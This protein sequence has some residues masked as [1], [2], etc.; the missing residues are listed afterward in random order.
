ML[1]VQVGAILLRALYFYCSITVVPISPPLLSSTLPTS[2]LP[3]SIKG[4]T[5]DFFGGKRTMK[6]A[7]PDW[8][9]PKVIYLKK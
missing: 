2:L 7:R 4:L 8:T 5:Y 9:I 1:V 6:A 3:Y